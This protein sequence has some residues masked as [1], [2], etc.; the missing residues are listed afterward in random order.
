MPPDALSDEVLV[1]RAR[2]EGDTRGAAEWLNTLFERYHT[3]VA[4][5]CLRL[6]GDRESALDLAQEVFIKAYRNIGHFRQ[7][8]RFSTWLYVITRNHCF[9]HVKALGRRPREL[10]AEELDRLAD[11]LPGNPAAPVEDEEARR[12]VDALLSL[13]DDT[14]REVMVLHY[15]EEMPLDAVTRML[16]LQNR[17][18]AKAYVVSARRK[19]KRAVERMKRVSKGA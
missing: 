19:L 17:S 15:G 1:E 7:E 2:A 12:Q 11:D 4:T 13:L 10:G 16:Q 9:N 6:T 8:S 5:W 3:R 18:G 14:E